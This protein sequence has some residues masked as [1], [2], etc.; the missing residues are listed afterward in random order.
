[1]PLLGLHLGQ[2]LCG[3]TVEHCADSQNL[4]WKRDRSMIFSPHLSLSPKVRV[5]WLT[6]VSLMGLLTG[7]SLTGLLASPR[8]LGSIWLHLGR[9]TGFRT[10]SP[11]GSQ[12]E[13]E[14]QVLDLDGGLDPSRA[15]NQSRTCR[16]AAAQRL[17]SQLDRRTLT[18]TEVAL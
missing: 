9:V 3:F 4:L 11:D 16:E 10:K 13:K 1:M 5:C 12:L 15:L 14:A 2:F 6:T 8:P 7:L 18:N 17:D